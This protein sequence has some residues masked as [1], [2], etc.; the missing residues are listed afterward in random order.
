MGE[1]NR[2]KPGRYLKPAAGRSSGKKLISILVVAV[3]LSALTLGGTFAVILAGADPVTNT[4]EPARMSCAVTEDFT[5]GVTKKDVCIQNTG[6]APVYIRVKLLP[7]WYEKEN[8]VVVAKTAWTPVFTPGTG[9]ML[10]ADGCYYYAE[11]VAPGEST[12]A[13]IPMVTLT[14]DDVSLARQVLEILPSCI[15][16]EPADAVLEAWTGTNG[17][18]TSVDGGS[19]V[20]AQGG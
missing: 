8:D 10:G 15:Q 6:D 1:K 12:A 19:L 11:P 14:Q 18:V 4:F 5:D 17:S 7:Y 9:W 2:K 16:A 13:L 20:V 3:L